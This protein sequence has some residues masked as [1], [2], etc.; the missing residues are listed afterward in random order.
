MTVADALARVARHHDQPVRGRGR[1]AG[2][3]VVVA[4]HAQRLVEASDHRVDIAVE[5]EVGEHRGAVDMRLELPRTRLGERVEARAATL[6]QERPLRVLRVHRVARRLRIDMAVD[7]EQVLVA[8][9][10]EVEEACA[11]PDKRAARRA[12]AELVRAVVEVAAVEVEVQRVGVAR[13]VRREDIGAAVAVDIGHGDAHRRLLA[14]LAVHGDA[15]AQSV[16]AVGPRRGRREEVVRLRIVADEDVGLAVAGEVEDR[17]IQP[18]SWLHRGDARVD[19]SVDEGPVAAVLVDRIGR[20]GVA[21]RARDH[22]HPL[23]GRGRQRLRGVEVEVVAHI[24]VE[25]AVEVEVGERGARAPARIGHA[26]AR[27]DVLEGAVALVPQQHIGPVA[28]DEDVVVPVCVD[29][30]DGAAEAPAAMADAA[31]LGDIAE[32]QPA[33]VAEEPRAGARLGVGERGAVRHEEIEVAVGVEVDEPEPAA[34]HLEHD[35]RG[36]GAARRRHREARLRRDIGEAD[37]RGLR[38]DGERG[39]RDRGRE[40]HH[41]FASFAGAAGCGCADDPFSAGLRSISEGL[42][43][44]SAGLRPNA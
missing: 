29:I 25:V 8:V 33:V 22:L 26:R 10:V 19:A 12:E 32:A 35:R 17:E 18:E 20:R 37:R 4:Q 30:A 34:L 40:R 13:E 42:R 11:P 15:R 3:R 2:G 5:V 14:A 38:I 41:G 16:V 43:P 6:H 24:E 39:E 1:I 36:R 7:R 21:A 31:R 27:R 28:G 9:V 44:F 23:E